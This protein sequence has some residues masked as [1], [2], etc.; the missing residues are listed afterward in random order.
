MIAPGRIYGWIAAED[1][2]CQEGFSDTRSKTT[3]DYSVDDGRLA[4]TVVRVSERRSRTSRPT[5]AS[6]SV[7]L[8]VILMVIHGVIGRE[9]DKP[10]CLR[11]R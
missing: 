10:K 9:L 8:R 11:L 2:F 6:R 4:P 3:Q 7:L 5:S 1:P